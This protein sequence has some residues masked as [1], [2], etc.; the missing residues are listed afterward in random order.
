M[1]QILKDRLDTAKVIMERYNVRF[2]TYADIASLK[3]QAQPLIAAPI[4]SNEVVQAVQ[5]HTGQCLFMIDDKSGKFGAGVLLVPLTTSGA[6]HIISGNRLGHDVDLKWVSGPDDAPKAILVWALIGKN[7]FYAG[8]MLG[9]C[10]A[11]GREVHHDIPVLAYAA[12]EDGARIMDRIG[13][14]PMGD[15]TDIY[16]WDLNFKR[17][18]EI[19]KTTQKNQAVQTPVNAS[20]LKT[21]VVNNHNDLLKV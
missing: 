7:T 21:I 4:A 6:Y 19:P 13:F 9:F 16:Q 15:D 12:T 8:K 18:R 11:M 14:K 20:K 1:S 5:E 10:R 2:P 3:Q 17:E